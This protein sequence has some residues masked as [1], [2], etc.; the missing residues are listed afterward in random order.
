MEYVEGLKTEWR[1]F[2]S[3]CSEQ[4][5]A[6]GRMHLKVQTF[7]VRSSATTGMLK[8]ALAGGRKTK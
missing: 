4:G 7:C 6:K 2:I 3:I 8:T 1:R 5:R